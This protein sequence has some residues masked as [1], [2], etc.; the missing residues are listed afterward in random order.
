MI[1]WNIFFIICLFIVKI[2]GQKT[3]VLHESGFRHEYALSSMT[4]IEN[5][6]DTT[7]CKYIAT[8]KVSGEHGDGLIG[9]SLNL[10]S[11]KAK[12]LGANMYTVQSYRQSEKDAEVIVRLFF[13]PEKLKKENDG[14]R[15]KNAIY[16]FNQYRGKEDTAYFFVNKEKT[17]FNQEKF[18]QINI[19]IGTVYNLEVT[20][21]NRGGVK[22][23]HT[24][25]NDA[26]FFI[27]PSNKKKIVTTATLN[28]MS[29][30]FKRNLPVDIDYQLGRFFV[31]VYK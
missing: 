16:V 24:K 2:K 28:S 7:R 10:L 30:G 23:L 1:R 17:I 21:T 5:I 20:P 4:M 26:L 12:Q 31:E 15:I 11:M 3:E 18:Y 19:V 29:I 25:P 6:A 9:N 27:I 13:A 14:K 22:V 8:V